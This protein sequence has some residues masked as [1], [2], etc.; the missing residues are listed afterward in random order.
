MK[1]VLLISLLFFSIHTTYSQTGPGGVGS[2][3]NNKLWL[4]ADKGVSLTGPNVTSWAD[5]SGN[6]NNALPSTAVNQPSFVSSSVNGYPSLDFDG[7][8]DELRVA[9]N[10]G[11]DVTS[12]HI[13]MVV[14][15]D[16]QKN[17][18]AWMVK[19]NDSQE[20]FELLSYNDGNLH[21][22]I[23]YTDATRTTPSAAA[24]QA[25]T[26]EF[27]IIEYSYTSTVG[28]DAYKNNGATII[29][30]NENKTPSNNNFEIYIGNE[31]GTSRF[32][33]GDIAEVII[34][35]TRLNSAQRIIVNNYLAA[36]YNKTLTNNDLY[37]EDA[38]GFDY[39]V[40][41]IGRIDASNLQ[42]DSRG[43]GIVRILNPNDLGDDEFLIWGHDNGILSATNTSDIPATI[44]A[45]SN[46]VWRVSERNS[47]N[48][49]NV[50]VGNVDIQFDFSGLGAIT[51]T[52]LRLLID[53][54]NDGVFADETPIGSASLVSGNI[55]QFAAV[56]GATLANN[57]RFTFATINRTQTPLPIELLSFT[58]KEVGQNVKVNWETATEINNDYF[59]LERSSDGQNFLQI[60]TVDGAGNSSANLQYQYMD[61]Q[62]LDGVSY[63]RLKQTDY[64]GNY[65][66]SS[67]KTVSINDALDL[68]VTIYPNPTSENQSSFVNFIG[69]AEE[70]IS[71]AIY[72]ISGKIIYQKEIQ[73]LASGNTTI[74]LK[75][76][77]SAGMYFINATSKSGTS[78]NQ[79]LIVK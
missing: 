47:T 23:V 40:A 18:N 9:D 63:Y 31:R 1:K 58:A 14:I 66:Y 46:R 35:N 44:Q 2:S 79:K 22:P 19:G 48:A 49:S 42:N 53:T 24:G 4:A 73:L 13:F 52:D 67:L 25:T 15:V 74:E 39:D 45:R 12:W 65:S 17:Y 10:A 33:D 61:H 62:P 55:Y 60:A 5:Q 77:F 43:S 64:D 26:T 57:R 50:N 28:R 70:L 3:V 56:P 36:K 76:H 75:H 6:G 34:Y 29:T 71:L 38:S 41:G 7:V 72:D 37:D 78:Y 16:A 54:D 32:V 20:N 21:T 11:L 30:D 59:S 51:V 68:N 69:N 27:N 8:N